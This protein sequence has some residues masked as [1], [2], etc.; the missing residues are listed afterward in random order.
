MSLSC[1]AATHAARPLVVCIDD[2]PPILAALRRQL[3][4]EPYELIT[5]TNPGQVLNLV[6]RRD[7]DV[8]MVDQ[9]MPLMTGTALLSAV[10]HRT[11]T[12]VCAVLTGYADVGWI[13]EAVNRG[14]LDRLI[15]KPWDDEELRATIRELIESRRD[16]RARAD[17]TP[18]S[19]WFD[20]RHEELIVRIRC[21]DRT[22]EEALAEA[23]EILRERTP[24][25]DHVVLVLEDLPALNGSVTHFLRDLYR[26]VLAH[27]RSACL[28]EPHGYARAFSFML[29]D[30]G[31][32]SVR[33]TVETAA[34][35]CRRRILM[36]DPNGRRL[37]FLTDLLRT[38]GHTVHVAGSVAEALKRPDSE[39]FDVLLHGLPEEEEERLARGLRERGLPTPVMMADVLP[40]LSPAEGSAARLRVRRRV[41]IA[42]C[43]R[44]LIAAQE[45]A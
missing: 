7:V 39:T 4:R 17:A 31:D 8:L 38:S 33:D 10:R 6:E 44:D 13:Q 15:L 27:A 21:R 1:D 23:A 25:F 26:N 36:I 35:E 28:I 16:R 12:T 40:G 3:R 32:P 45:S 34:T 24:S 37:R 43:L 41:S 14:T 22:A 19:P 42:C 20:P 9:R 5:T 2:E 11:P 29:K 18:V 30:A